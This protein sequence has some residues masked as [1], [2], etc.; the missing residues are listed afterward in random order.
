MKKNISSADRVIRIFAAIVI[1]TLILTGTLTG[2]SAWIL[3]II[4]GVLALTSLVGLCPLY[5]MLGLS[6][7]KASPGK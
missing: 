2:T 3:G 5:L 7:A 1:V 4:A 6:T